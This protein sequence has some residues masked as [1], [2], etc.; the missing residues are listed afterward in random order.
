MCDKLYRMPPVNKM[1]DFDDMM[2]DDLRFDDTIIDELDYSEVASYAKLYRSTN[3]RMLEKYL[4][5]VAKHPR[6]EL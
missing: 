1:S 2:F 4:E 5:K 6:E 3:V